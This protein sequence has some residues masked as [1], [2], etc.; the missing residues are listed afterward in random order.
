MTLAHQGWSKPPHPSL[1]CNIDAL[2]ISKQQRTTLGMIL[3]DENGK[4]VSCQTKV[5][6]EAPMPS[7]AE[8]LALREVGWIRELQK[9]NILIELDP[10]VPYKKT[11]FALVKV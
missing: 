2:V 11:Y 4:V 7:K 9:N 10:R 5:L 8:A 3:K 1:K 6:N